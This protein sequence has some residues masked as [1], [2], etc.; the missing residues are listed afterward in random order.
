MP[1]MTFLLLFKYDNTVLDKNKY[2]NKQ[3][4]ILCKSEVNE[5]YF[6]KKSFFLL[7]YKKHFS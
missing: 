2:F 4:K 7:V 6:N 5:C 3:K 1:F